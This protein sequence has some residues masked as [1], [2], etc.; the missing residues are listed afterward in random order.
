[1]KINKDSNLFKN[2]KKFVY[3]SAITGALLAGTQAGYLVSTYTAHADEN[4][5]SSVVNLN[6][7]DQFGN[8]I[9][10]SYG[11]NEVTTANYEI[12]VEANT[13]RSKDYFIGILQLQFPGVSTSENNIPDN[14]DLSKP[15]TYTFKLVQPTHTLTVNL[16]DS[17]NNVVNTKSIS[18]VTNYGKSDITDMFNWANEHNYDTNGFPTLVSN[19]ENVK[20][21]SVSLIKNNDDTK[22]TTAAP[23]SSASQSSQSFAVA[24]ST[25]STI[26]SSSS[27]HVVQSSSAQSSSSSQI[28]HSSNA[29][30]NSTVSSSANSVVSSQSENPIHSQAPNHNEAVSRPYDPVNYGE[31]SKTRNVKHIKQSPVDFI[32]NKANKK[33]PQTGDNTHQ[34]RAIALGV[35]T[36]AVGLGV[37]Y[38]GLRK[39]NK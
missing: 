38:Y 37:A 18:G 3:V 35:A 10:K 34:A 20:N 23:S 31:E 16:V 7:V 19:G 33:L 27:S 8:P 26:Q 25:Q 17:S 22:T 2:T 4:V 39:R 21:I 13:T 32:E 30:S 36:I 9:Q 1:M 24:S 29:E 11:S 6:F 5:Q 14:I 28:F 15:A 12:G